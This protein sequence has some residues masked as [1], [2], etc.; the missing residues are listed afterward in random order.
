M[1]PRAD[2]NYHIKVFLHSTENWGDTTPL[3]HGIYGLR[4]NHSSTVCLCPAYDTATYGLP[5]DL[6]RLGY[7]QDVGDIESADKARALA[8]VGGGQLILLENDDHAGQLLKATYPEGRDPDLPPVPA[9]VLESHYVYCLTHAEYMQ[10]AAELA[11]IQ[12]REFDGSKPQ[13]QPMSYNRL[14]NFNHYSIIARIQQLLTAY[15]S[16]LTAHKRELLGL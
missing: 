12:S 15:P 8:V 3:Y 11:A 7:L 9:P 6:S 16:I 13:E 14:N 5:T 2:A 4:L 1:K 10:Y